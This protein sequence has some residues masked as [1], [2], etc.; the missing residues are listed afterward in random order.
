MAQV[1]GKAESHNMAVVYG[2]A[3]SRKVG[4]GFA[5]ENCNLGKVERSHNLVGS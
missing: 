2:K 4:M 3:D 5:K 1:Y